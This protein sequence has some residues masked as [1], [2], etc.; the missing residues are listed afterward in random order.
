M[1]FEKQEEMKMPKINLK[2]IKPIWIVSFLLAVCL[3]F[4][5]YQFL[6]KKLEEGI[7]QRGVLAGQQQ[8]NN[9][10]VNQFLTTGKI[11][12]N[13]PMSDSGQ[14]DPQGVLQ[15][16]FLVPITNATSVNK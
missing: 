14:Y 3:I 5:L 10:V 16:I 7:Y 15:T 9:M 11:G 12:I 2:K 8:V 13:I 4:I 6:W 1:E